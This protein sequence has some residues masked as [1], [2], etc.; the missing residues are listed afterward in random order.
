[1]S[2]YTKFPQGID[3]KM[4]LP[5]SI[6]N[7][8]V[9]TPNHENLHANGSKQPFA[10]LV[11]SRDRNIE[12]YPNPNNYVIQVPR[13]KDVLSVEIISADIPH[14]GFNIDSSNN[15]IYVAVTQEMFIQYYNGVRI[16]NVSYIEVVIPPGYYEA[17]D[18]ASRN[19]QGP[20]AGTNSTLTGNLIYQS[21]YNYDGPAIYNGNTGILATAFKLAINNYMIL[22]NSTVDKDKV[23]FY[24]VLDLKT[25]KYTIISTIKF[26]I[27]NRD[28]DTNFGNQPKPD[29]FINQTPAQAAD[30]YLG[31]NNNRFNIMPR[32][33]Y[34]VL[35]FD[36]KNYFPTTTYSYVDRPYPLPAAAPDGIID[37][38]FD[39]S[40]TSY[41]QIAQ[42]QN[43][44]WPPPNTV[45]FNT[46]YNPISPCNA[47]LTGL[48]LSSNATI[49]LLGNNIVVAYSLPFRANMTGEKYI[50]LDIPE[51]N[52]RDQTNI[53]NNQFYCRILLD[54][55]LNVTPLSIYYNNGNFYPT[56]L[57]I[58]NTVKAI[59][60]ADIGNNRAI[61]Y[62]APSLGVL[63][64]LT[65]RWLKHD[66][67][68]YDFQGQDHSI[69]FEILTIKQTGDY[70]N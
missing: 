9:F 1:M 35:G 30:S 60:G 51:L 68:P 61:K 26:A 39:R 15:T 58:I 62:F 55:P 64:K 29:F 38:A 6:K 11:D 2:R 5:P 46:P 47:G 36:A 3:G 67:T 25:L 53:I 31:A 19:P 27:L 12:L 41:V 4:P 32:C 42:G 45:N 54:T 70:F 43:Y 50:I 21:Y 20:A 69:G 33:A 65:I 16:P 44:Y 24:T 34:N 66:G 37:G 10:L 23:Y 49:E 17:S 52:Y 40:E 56:S 59:K 57:S 18:L 14:S 63:A 28:T 48:P 8:F 13:Y 22:I 7:D